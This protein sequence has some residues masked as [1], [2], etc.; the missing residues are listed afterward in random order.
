M[1]HTGGDHKLT[2]HPTETQTTVPAG[3]ISHNLI[4]PQFKEEVSSFLTVQ[5]KDPRINTVLN[6]T[7]PASTPVPHKPTYTPVA[8]PKPDNLTTTIQTNHYTS[9]SERH[10]DNK[11]S[12]ISL[13]AP[14]PEISNLNQNC[15]F[16][17]NKPVP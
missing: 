8:V 6:F 12:T 3:D 9:E 14:V 13:V 1:S 16:Q 5:N 2:S 4:V 17:S 11:F 7:T 15:F 10:L